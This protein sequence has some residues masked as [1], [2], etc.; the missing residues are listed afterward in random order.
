[1]T[2]AAPSALAASRAGFKNRYM[3]SG[4]RDTT[5]VAILTN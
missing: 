1:M 4:E 3:R 5:L 2:A